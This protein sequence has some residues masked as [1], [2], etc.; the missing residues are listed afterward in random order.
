MEAE[1]SKH[2]IARIEAA[3]ARIEAAPVTSGANDGGTDLAALS[4]K[5]ARLRDAVQASLEQLD[6]LIEGAQG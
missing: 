1:R 5:H 3:L 2:A 6:Q 4:A